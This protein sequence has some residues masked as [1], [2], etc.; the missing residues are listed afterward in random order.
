MQTAT[1]FDSVKKKHIFL[2]VDTCSGLMTV[3]TTREVD[4]WVR[5]MKCSGA[6]GLDISHFP[7]LKVALHPHDHLL[8]VGV[9]PSPVLP[10]SPSPEPLPEGALRGLVGEERWEGEVEVEETKVCGTFCRGGREGR[11]RVT[12]APGGH[13]AWLC[14]EYRG[15]RWAGP[16]GS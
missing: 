9:D 14:G 15:D 1:V 2:V 4:Q 7:E 11:C 12:P 8:Q 6:T 3:S 13:L 16:L 5:K 10:G